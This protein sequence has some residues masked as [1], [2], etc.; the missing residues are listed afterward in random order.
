M[1]T[2]MPLPKSVL[3]VVAVLGAV[4]ALSAL[5]MCVA[6]VAIAPHAV[7][8]V[9]GFELIMVVAGVIAVLFARG[10][11]AEGQGLT[12]LC[13]AGVTLAGGFLSYL[14]TAGSHGIVFRAGAGPT[15]MVPWLVFRTVIGLGFLLMAS[16]AVLRRSRDSVAYL[17]RGVIASI[18]LGTVA[19]VT[20]LTRGTLA[21]APDAVRGVVWAFVGV[22]ALIGIAAAGHSFIRAF[23]C[24]RL[25]DAKQGDRA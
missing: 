18:V 20:L 5:A 10:A 21:N 14:A 17:K 9:F 22:V 19:G 13:V 23:E 3:R 24:G 12:L 15:S 7:W 11:F 8:V 4:L 25:E 6:S 16:Y 1:S 2:V